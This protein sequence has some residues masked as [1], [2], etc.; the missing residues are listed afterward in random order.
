MHARNQLSILAIAS[1]CL[2]TGT[3]NAQVARQIP[4]RTVIGVAGPPAAPPSIV[5]LD[6]GRYAIG[7]PGAVPS[8]AT[9]ATGQVQVFKPGTGLPD[10][11]NLFDG[12]QGIDCSTGAGSL[13]EVIGSLL[14]NLGDLDNDGEE[15]YGMVSLNQLIAG[16]PDC[17][18]SGVEAV[19]LVSGGNQARFL[20]ATSGSTLSLAPGDLIGGM[21]RLDVMS[22][23]TQDTAIAVSVND[24]MMTGRVLSI[25]IFQDPTNP[26]GL[27][28]ITQVATLPTGVSAGQIVPVGDWNND[29]QDDFALQTN[30]A[31][32]NDVMVYDGTAFLGG[33]LT[34]LVTLPSG[35]QL[36][37]T[38]FSPNVRTVAVGD[39]ATNTVT[40]SMPVTGSSL[41]VID[42]VVTTPAAVALGGSLSFGGDVDGDGKE[43]L[44]IGDLALGGQV[45]VSSLEGDLQPRAITPVAGG[46]FGSDV[47][48]L[49]D[50]NGDGF[51]EVLVL[52][53]V[54]ANVTMFY[55]GPVAVATAFG[56]GCTSLTAPPPT[57]AAS[58]P[59]V[60][61]AA[62]TIDLLYDGLTIGNPPGGPIN[63]TFL[64]GVD[65]LPSPLPLPGFITGCNLLV[66]SLGELIPLGGTTVD[67][68]GDLTGELP[69]PTDVLFL[70]VGFSFQAVV[71]DTSIGL[72]I[73]VSNGLTLTFGW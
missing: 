39:P 44:L 21:C 17:L 59:P 37:S 63:G 15:D 57:L 73:E 18:D 60:V 68:M 29:G 49:D 58:Q 25:T 30:I 45:F 35:S 69:A 24:S 5:A 54:N 10:P 26:P 32:T 71:V 12:V 16:G 72:G 28:V 33:T 61:G 50:Q 62:G 13:P 52:D 53:V 1:L 38:T 47:A 67:P 9:L 42:T 51:D 14:T 56:T 31:S 48:I 40:I 66:D 36:A 20:D 23:P 11:P 19:V 6:S 7:I 27:F 41:S 2:T 22:G 3:A 65:P 8:S 64:W 34:P 43:D 46:T 4:A 55:G 70:G